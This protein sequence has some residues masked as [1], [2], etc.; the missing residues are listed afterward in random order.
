VSAAQESQSIRDRFPFEPERDE[1]G[2]LI[3]EKILNRRPRLSGRRYIIV[4]TLYTQ[5]IHCILYTLY[6][7][8]LTIHTLY[9]VNT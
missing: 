7:T 4:Y 2:S 1:D 8:H 6:N 9:T 5:Y 3:I